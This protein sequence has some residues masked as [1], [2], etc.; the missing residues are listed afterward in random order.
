[1]RTPV[2]LSAGWLTDLA[3]LRHTGSQITD[4]GDHLVIRSPRNPLF[5]WGNFLLVTDPASAD[6]APRWVATFAREFPGA[7]H[8]ALGLQRL[9]LAEPYARVGLDVGTDDVLTTPTLPEQRPLPEPYAARAFADDGDWAALL[10]LNIDENHWEA[11]FPEAEHRAYLIGQQAARRE[12]VARGLGQ[13]F[14][15]FDAEGALAAYL[16]IVRCDEL[17][18][19]QAVGT[20]PAHRR[21]GLAGHLLGGAARWAGERGVTRWVIVTESVNPAGR[22]YR[23][24]GFTE[25][26]VQVSAYRPAP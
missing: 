2:K 15:A 25:D 17:G 5:H 24:V 22:L 21:H 8:L 20:H 19:Y 3:I 16:G 13:W 9:P 18:R 12:L 7:T 1:M 26:A 14:G 11:R 4:R 6:D 10:A 23:S